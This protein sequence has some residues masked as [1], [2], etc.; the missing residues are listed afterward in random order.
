MAEKQPRKGIPSWFKWGL[1]AFG[2][3]AL[4][5]NLITKREEPPLPASE[6]VKQLEPEEVPPAR[7]TFATLAR[8]IWGAPTLHVIEVK[9]GEGVEALCGQEVAVRYSVYSQTGEE[10]F[11]NHDDPEPLRYRLGENTQVPALERGL[12]GMKEG[13]IRRIAAPAELSYGL[14]KFQKEGI[15]A[16]EPVGFEVKLVSAAP[17]GAH[18]NGE[19]FKSLFRWYDVGIGNGEGIA[20]GHRVSMLLRVTPLDGEPLFTTGFESDSNPL[21]ITVGQDSLP[22]GLQ[23][24]LVGMRNQARRTVVMGSDY[25]ALFPQDF[26]EED[27]VKR[28]PSAPEQQKEKMTET[29]PSPQASDAE[30]SVAEEGEN[31]L[32]SQLLS[33]IEQAQKNGLD[34]VVMDIQILKREQP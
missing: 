18:R 4:M 9:A 24:A 6:A 17:D 3:Y 5:N 12:L 10:L 33:R 27:E 20:C 34:G 11:T 31:A 32:L 22:F 28:E 25:L 26:Q 13:A 21:K 19:K 14:P 15:P 16:N 7:K 29:T 2:A 1:L 8:S 23:Q 30:T